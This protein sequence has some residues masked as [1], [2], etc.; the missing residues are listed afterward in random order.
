M[1][2]NKER[3]LPMNFVLELNRFQFKQSIFHK[4]I[5]EWSFSKTNLP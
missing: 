2:F 3:Y 5:E 4:T 1:A